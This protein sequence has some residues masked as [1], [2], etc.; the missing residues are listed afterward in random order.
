MSIPVEIYQTKAFKKAEKLLG[1]DRAKELLTKDSEVLKTMIGEC[2][3]EVGKMET[4]LKESVDYRRSQDTLK[5]LRT[6][7][8]DSTE[9]HRITAELAKKIVNMRQG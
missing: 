9:A 2:V 7:F 4:Q 6:D 3:A 5:S 8:K 1:R